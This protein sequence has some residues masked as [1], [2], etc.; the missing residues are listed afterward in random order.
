MV[1]VAP[2]M[3]GSGKTLLPHQKTK[4]PNLFGKGAQVRYII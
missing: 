2:N 1:V 3:Q 4:Q